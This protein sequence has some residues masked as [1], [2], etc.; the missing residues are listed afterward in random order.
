MTGRNEARWLL[1]HKCKTKDC[2]H[3][4]E[5]VGATHCSLCMIEPCASFTGEQIIAMEQYLEEINDI[6]I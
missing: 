5:Y 4:T 1:D 3:W 6:L 2:W